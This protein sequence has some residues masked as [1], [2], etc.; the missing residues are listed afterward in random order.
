MAA[1][2][3][4]LKL[5]PNNSIASE[6]A[7]TGAGGAD[8]VLFAEPAYETASAGWVS[9]ASCTADT[10]AIFVVDGCVFT[11][12]P[13]AS[14]QSSDM[15]MDADPGTGYSLYYNGRWAVFGGTSFVAPELAGMFAIAVA[16]HSNARLGVAGGSSLLFCV[17]NGPNLAADFNDITTGS[18]GI[19]GNHIFDA[20]TGWDHPTGW[21]SPKDAETLINDIVGC[22]P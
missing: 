20:A 17:A 12:T 9:N 14:R 11:G 19:A 13:T 3:T 15:S 22:V 4:H 7:W 21:G 16:Q 6:S 1:G 2:G 5:N 18:S 10:T 8:S